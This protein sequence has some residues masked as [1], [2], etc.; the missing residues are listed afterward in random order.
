MKNINILLLLCLCLGL[1]AQITING[2]FDDW[3][4][5]DPIYTDKSGDNASSSV[6]FKKIWMT[7]DKEFIYIRFETTKEIN[8]QEPNN[9]Y[10]NFD[11]DNNASTGRRDNGLGIDLKYGF[12]NRSGFRYS[13]SGSGTTVYHS[14]VALICAP[15][16]SA[17]EFELMISRANL[18]NGNVI[19]FDIED[20]NGD[21][22][23]DEKGIKYT[24]KQSS[25][26]YN[27]YQLDRENNPNIIRLMTYNGLRDKI[28][29][30]NAKAAFQRMVKAL[31]PDIIAFQELYDTDAVTI[32][33]HVQS[34][35]GG[36]W[37]AAKAS[38][39]MVLVSKY[40]IK[41]SFTVQKEAGFII[42]RNGDEVVIFN[43]HLACC[44]NNTTRQREVDQLMQFIRKMKQNPFSIGLNG[45][46]PFF[47]VGD[48]NLVGKSRQL[49]T[50]LTGDISSNS[51]YGADFKPDLD[52][53]DLSFAETST[54]GLPAS[55]TWYNSSSSYYPGRLDYIIYTD[56][57][58]KMHHSFA[59]LT[60]RLTK[61]D[62]TKYK[63]SKYD[64][65]IA[66]DHLPTVM[67]FSLPN[68]VSTKDVV[69]QGVKLSKI[70]NGTHNISVENTQVKAYKLI[71]TMGDIVLKGNLNLGDN[72]V[73][74]DK[75]PFGIYF[76]NIIQSDGKN[77]TFKVLK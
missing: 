47:I 55:V 2:K 41:K 54:T 5:I 4:N 53:S 35:L 23:P 36:D 48:S 19:Q 38:T 71:N 58:I 72:Y 29:S 45:D 28:A 51:R 69:L 9:L 76:I 31:N 21:K 18:D 50:L 25:R 15:T 66:S 74:T 59:L 64:S 7:N 40:E 13:S 75:L 63:L 12:G 1:N 34:T 77:Q 39:D 62:L 44:D 30:G 73:S 24:I 8:L 14:D 10:I 68:S 6:D 46:A 43:M 56:S 16:V 32:K 67:D 57:E 60:E 26:T 22:A 49:K 37:Y 33:N 65:Q 70:G 42:D 20:I 3:K 27:N 17:T 61:N 52:D 11:L